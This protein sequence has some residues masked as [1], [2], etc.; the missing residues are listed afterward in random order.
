MKQIELLAKSPL[1]L[2][3]S[4]N[5]TL[6]DAGLAYAEERRANSGDRSKPLA[7]LVDIVSNTV[8]PH[9]KAHKST[10]FQYID[11]AEVNEVL[12]AIMSYRELSGQMIGSSKVR[13]QKEHILFAKIRP[14]IDNKKVAFVYQELENAVASTEFIVLSA[15]E[16][17]N[18]YYLYAAIRS[19]E[20]TQSVIGECGG[21]TGRQRIKPGQLLRIGIP[22]PDKDVRDTIAA[23][24]EEFFKALSKTEALRQQAVEVAFE[25]LGTTSMRTAQPRRKR[26]KKS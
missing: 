3:V 5:S 19:D 21:D 15:K 26:T 4:I 16:G 1:C 17:I 6:L 20:F 12:G 14:S 18:P 2:T 24:V 8:N 23:R 13:F 9:G 11:L 25:A 7:E 22:W 10:L